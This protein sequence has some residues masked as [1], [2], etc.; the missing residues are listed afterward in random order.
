MLSLLVLEFTQFFFSFFFGGEGGGRRICT[1]HDD[2]AIVGLSLLSIAVQTFNMCQFLFTLQWPVSA[3]ALSLESDSSSLMTLAT[4][5]FSMLYFTIGHN[6]FFKNRLHGFPLQIHYH[7]FSM[8]SYCF[9]RGS[10]SSGYECERT[11]HWS[12][13][14]P[15]CAMT[16]LLLV[17]S[18]SGRSKQSRVVM[19]S[20]PRKPAE[21]PMQGSGSGS[22][23]L[24][25]IQHNLKVLMWRY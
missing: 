19:R 13:F 12:G 9:M 25:A 14:V 21:Q 23:S 8:V 1:Y 3:K 24:G 5:V 18:T 6:I 10:D 20:G 2:V 11:L 15:H 7:S 16:Y 22:Q 4:F 17:G